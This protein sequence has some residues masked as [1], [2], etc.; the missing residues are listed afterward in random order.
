MNS[1]KEN[2]ARELQSLYTENTKKYVNSFSNVKS[3]Q[4]S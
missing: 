3:S 2:I 4:G 1:D